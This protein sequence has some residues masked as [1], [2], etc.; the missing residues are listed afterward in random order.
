MPLRS[1]DAGD[2]SPTL[3]IIAHGCAVANAGLVGV[4][5]H[6]PTSNVGERVW[7]GI[8]RHSV[9]LTP[10]GAFPIVRDLVDFPL[11][12]TTEK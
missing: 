8:S 10:F 2:E 9:V 4:D 12:P 1:C 6:L 7:L 5:G 3:L 11:T